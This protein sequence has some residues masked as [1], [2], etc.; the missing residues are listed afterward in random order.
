[1]GN[2][3]VT[4]TSVEEILPLTPLQEGLLFHAQLAEDGPAL[5][6]MQLSALLSGPLDVAA[7]RSA[8][9]QLL[10]RHQSL[11][12]C[13]RQD[14]SNKTVQVVRREVALPWR[15]VDLSACDDELRGQR[16]EELTLEAQS[17]RFDFTKAPLM[18]FLLV[19]LAP[20]QHR[21]IVTNHHVVV[22]GW[23]ASVL[24]DEL[25]ELYRRS[26]DA[27]GMPAPP[28][29][30]LFYSWLARQDRAAARAAWGTALAGLT[31]PT[32][33]APADPARQPVLPEEITVEVPGDLVSRLRSFARGHGLTLNT[34][35]Q[36]ALG[37]L[38]GH[39]T[40]RSDTVFG[41]T[42]S[43]RSPEVQG[44]ET[45][46]GM[47][48]N[49]VPVRV[50][51]DLNRP[52]T[53]TALLARLQAEQSQLVAHHHLGLVD[54]QRLAGLTELFD[55]HLVF[56]NVPGGAV[57]A[58]GALPMSDMKIAGGTNYSLSITVRF[59]GETIS[60]DVEYRPDLFDAAGART[61]AAGLVR[62]LEQMAAQP[63]APA[64]QMEAVPAAERRALL[65]QGAGTA[66][67]AAP[68]ADEL[69]ARLARTVPG[70][71]AVACGP[72]TLTFGE[73]AARASRLARRLITAGARP[74]DTVAVLL[75]RS[76]DSIVALL[77]IATAGATY[78]PVDPGY[79]PARVQSMLTD[80]AP[81]AVIT[82]SALA[83]T[84]AGL[85]AAI[86]ALDDPACLDGL[87]DGPVRDG[88]RHAPRSPG[89]AAYLIYT[90]GS[91]GRAKGVTVTR[92]SLASLL[93][94]QHAEIITP[95]A[96][97][98]GRRLRAALVAS[99]SFDA[100]WN[101]IAWLLAGHELHILDDDTRRDSRELIRYTRQHHIDVIEITPSYATQ[102]VEDGLLDPAGHRPSVLIMGGEA[103]PAPLWQR[104]AREP[105]VAGYNFYGPTE[106]TIDTATSPITG[107]Q[108]AIGRPVH[109]TA[110]YVLDELLRPVPAGVPGDLYVAGTAVARGYHRQPALTA[111]RFVACP[112]GPPGSRMYATG[113]QARRAPDGTL[114][115]LGRTDD[116]AKIRGFRVEP[117]EIAATLAASPHVRQAA[118]T[119]RTDAA[120]TSQLIAYIVPATIPAQLD[121]IRQHAATQ[122]PEHMVPA[123][124]VELDALPLTPNGKLDRTALPDPAHTE[125]T[126]GRA[127]RTARQ[128]ILCG[129]VAELLERE[130]VGIDDNF[131]ELGGHSL[132]AMQFVGRARRVFGREITLRALFRAPTVAEL[133]A[134]ID[135]A[136][137]ARPPL[138]PQDRPGLV[139]LSFA[140]RRLWFLNRLEGPSPTYNISGAIRLRG[141]L[142][143]RALAEAFGDLAGRHEALRTVFPEVEGEPRQRVLDARQAWP[144]LA[145]VDC[146]AGQLA[147]ALHAAAT[148]AFDV[149][150]EAAPL[151]VT[152]F[153]V[154]PD[155]HALLVVVHHIAADGWSLAPM[156]RDLAVAYQA[157]RDWRAPDWEPLPVQYADYTLWQLDL[158][159][160]ASDPASIAAGQL[161]YWRQQLAGAPECLPLPT[162][163][164][165][166]PFPSYRG[167]AVPFTLDAEL[168]GRLADLARRNGAT[169]FMVFQ[170]ALATLLTRWG[171][172]TDI[173]IGSPLAGR[174]DAALDDLVGFF[175]NTVVLRTDTSGNPT[176]RQLLHR[177][178]E[179]DLAAY[180]NQDIPFE[181]VVEHLNPPRSLSWNP[182]FQVML[183]LQN[184]PRAAGLFPGLS[185][186]M[187]AVDLVTAKVDLIIEAS[188]DADD[189]GRPAG[190]HGQV[191]YAVDLF[192]PATA[193]ALADG[194]VR[195]LQEVSERPNAP[196]SRVEVIPADQQ[197][198]LLARGAG[199][200]VAEDLAGP[201][202]LLARQAAA[203]GGQTALV[204][205]PVAL[206]FGELAARASR[207]AR[208]LITAGAGPEDRVVVLLPRCADSVVALLA[209]ATA[210]ATYVPVDPAYPTARVQHM[211]HDSAPVAVIT[212]L[213]LAGTLAGPDA[214]IITLDDP[215]CL[216][217]LADGPVGDDERRAPHSPDHAAYLI[218]TS[219]STGRPKG[220]TVTRRSL[221]NLMAFHRNEIV[222][223]AAIRAGR[224]LRA[225]LAYSLSFDASWNLVMWLLAGHELHILDDDTRRDSRELIRYTRQH[226]IDVSWA[227]RPS[228]PPSG[229]GSPGSPQWPATT[230]TAPPSARSMPPPPAL[231]GTT[232]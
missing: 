221:A 213:A 200:V 214:A 102:L 180:D 137:A 158:L 83:G 157:R 167:A 54:V 181:R 129:M 95:A 8:C 4:S 189:A 146:E 199:P 211:L 61:L 207:L 63:D 182:L 134:V 231:A 205:G 232:R 105:A 136:D 107:S 16:L 32:L 163:R 88:E 67:A 204:Y 112:Y 159:G 195:V 116:Q 66:T 55:T 10:A 148:H 6:T 73:L 120:G 127:P 128:E 62:V 149:T 229:N 218:Y 97:R 91:T 123:T 49:T 87:P 27:T 226:H 79:P 139:P 132:L 25:S 12:A 11:R 71:V 17:A 70:A 19:R 9:G 89:H 84:L 72:V 109:N 100:S 37:L 38:L 76:A 41:A 99:L 94:Y 190:V 196:V 119:T 93:A 103:I 183:A 150:T 7:L 85:D 130:Q 177:V 124:Y 98:A 203:A 90:S 185:V 169:M 219:G 46:V 111:E 29:Y 43:G 56:Q 209:I 30:R 78:V 50:R 227:A 151:R 59:T 178:R 114:E 45:M 206:T 28:P 60:M 121:S 36:G 135:A 168:H 154:A 52:E 33:L 101:L 15:Q 122:L 170:A 68:P 194:L 113:D 160:D 131:F 117:A 65:A 198:A 165:R 115:F 212:T 75:P 162:D 34:V 172:G 202:E 222:Y 92:A 110:C 64:S 47:L 173:P 125:P 187:E 223:P 224:R 174:T 175:V 108:P 216:D 147:A 14:K 179:T 142:D 230:S 13:F 141:P 143:R 48:I 118:V 44:I 80:A 133:D 217:G 144:D 82:T 2:G 201:D 171:T 21:F 24:L 138:R 5:Y 42:V 1:M 220:V 153:T 77:A 53:V 69:L 96:E 51:Q 40:G 81:T 176:F 126:A 186:E 58:P 140:Q 152:L 210:G 39:A 86:I 26:G 3:H 191:Q 228:P 166:P 104:I 208:R 18:R 193:R 215:A 161:A 197:R 225:A 164:P 35:F 74:E 184:T 57:G 156:L 20:D 106:C 145:V 192:D 31:G 155:E 22:D 188:E 23:S